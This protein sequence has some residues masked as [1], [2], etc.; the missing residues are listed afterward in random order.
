M[1]LRLTTKQTFTAVIL[2]TLLAF[3]A[4]FIIYYKQSQHE[5]DTAT[6]ITNT[7]DLLFYTERISA[8]A[9]EIETSARGYL[10]TG[11][12]QFLQ[13]YQKAK[14]EMPGE[15]D[16]L[17]QL[18]SLTT[19]RQQHIDSLLQYVNSRILFSDSIINNRK[20]ISAEQAIQL[21]AN[22]GGRIY[23]DNV[24]RLVFRMQEDEKALLEVNKKES[25]QELFV[26][27]LVLFSVAGIM[28]LLLVLLFWQEKQRIEDKERRKARNELE[29]L[30]LQVNQAHDAIYVV[31]KDL[32]IKSWNKGAEK[33]YGFSA[34]EV[35]NRNPNDVLQT[36]IT[37]AEIDLALQKINAEDYWTGELKR[38]T[39]NGES[40]YVRSSTTTIRNEEQV[41]TGYV[42]V[43]FDITGQ[44]QLREQVGHLANL[45]EQS[46]EAIIS[47]GLDECIRSW[48]S[49]AEQLFGYKKEE[50]IGRSSSELGYIK[51]SGSELFLIEKD[52]AEKGMWVSERDFYHK[53]GTPFFG[54]VTGNRIANENGETTSMV[55][56]IKDM[57][58]RRQ[59][60]EQLT[61]SNEELEE[62]VRQRTDEIKASEK[63]Y[64]YLFENNPMPMW[65][66]DLK[67]FRFLD[68]NKMA[69]LQYG[70]SRQEF[71]SMT[72][73]D[74]RPDE[75]KELFVRSDHAFTTNAANYNRGTWRHKKKDGTIITVEIIAHEIIFDGVPARF[76]LSNDITEKKKVEEKLRAS[77]E[78]FR[79]SMDN[80]LE[81]VQIIDFDWRYIYVN[82][83]MAK[84]GRY[85][86]E[87][88][89]GH[90]VMEM[91]PG[92]EE[93]PIYQTYLKC[94][95][96]R[97]TIHLENEFVF[98]DG[99]SAW[100]ELSFQPVPEGIFILSVDITDRKKAEE[101]LQFNEKRFRTL[102]EDNHDIITLMD[103]RFKVFYRSPSAARITG[104]SDEEMEESS[105][106]NKFTIHPDDWDRADEVMKECLA[107]PGKPVYAIY[108][109]KHKEGHYIWLEGTV[110]N[111][112]NNPYVS[113]VLF[114][115]RDVTKRIESEEKILSSE[116]RFRSLIENISD[117]IVL[118]DEQ[119]NIIYQ[120]PSVE[121]IL[122][123]SAEERKGKKVI[124]YI[125]PDNRPDIIRLYEEL[126]T[127]KNKPLSFQ[128]RFL[129]KNG[130]YI[131]L[132]GVVTNL[133]DNPAVNAYVA[134][135]RDITERKETEIRI[136]N[137]NAELEERVVKRTEQLR[138][139]NE[140]LE[141]FSYSVS[142]DLRAPL[143]AIIGFSAILEEDYSSKLDEEAKRITAIIKNNTLKMGSLIDDLLAFSR[144]GRQDI[145]TAPVHMPELVQ[146]VIDNEDRKDHGLPV[147][148]I[149]HPL[150]IVKADIN[151]LRQVWINLVS[152]AVKY[153]GNEAAPVIEIGS[154]TATNGQL[155]FFV[156]D[157]GVGFDEKYKNKLFKVFQ[158]LHSSEEFEGTGIGLAIV[159]KI[160][161]KH[162]GNV[163]AE[164][165]PGQG[166]CFYF[167]LPAN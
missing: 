120:S 31:D 43:S 18:A 15:V 9:A 127:V 165:A 156:K 164:S 146:E 2:L 3:G 95:N 51:L 159:E 79:Q 1:P 70:Y 138:K 152:N 135:Y 147:Q 69:V 131:W 65:V 122:G 8:T 98:P 167:S 55:F 19:Y 85:T 140:E 64:R 92:I 14:N 90:T 119:T 134:N 77:E 161:S 94:F 44:K 82:E 80:M 54:S 132:E 149:V 155:A 28:L 61:R 114:N 20:N 29:F 52:M 103:R 109:N 6:S 158:R 144:M 111:L 128:Y 125:H 107:N 91:Y 148:W 106:N 45:V 23:L 17:K 93:A 99:T 84:H 136:R 40:I 34:E 76:I 162:G 124:D 21:V 81:G 7:Q 46:S 10:L 72:A 74:I 62:K 151:T 160:I 126:K 5:K 11:Q 145:I 117:A 59:L 16:R 153:S 105:G 116:V 88:L 130:K 154:F 142:H 68:V 108:R 133:M 38:V 83:S 78:Q 150:P 110:T 22:G 32:K 123:Y 101:Q 118:N 166:A 41:V 100:F 36:A 67:T 163:W 53:D 157:N 104:W 37:S 42:A 73:T 89:I 141:A 137:L 26:E 47:I 30:S 96:E 113:A 129:Q 33:L 97:A 49:G 71:L 75:D 112:L 143:R 13:T 66:I 60:E 35:M 50:A 24:R 87:Q 57:S 25:A 86:K 12:D 4:I 56:I 115:F 121:R 139:T 63:K 39:K 48:N 58:L 27:R 102:I